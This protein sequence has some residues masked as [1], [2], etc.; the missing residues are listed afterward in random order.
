MIPG[1]KIAGTLTEADCRG[2][3]TA[4][5]NSRPTRTSA[6][7]GMTG[8][9][10]AKSAPSPGVPIDGPFDADGAAIPFGTERPRTVTGQTGP[11]ASHEA[12][13]GK[14]EARGAKR[15]ARGARPD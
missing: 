14:R 9:G 4:A 3:G 7:F 11:R 2:S 12:R 10:M 15:E 13:G 5:A 6:G 1:A 8:R